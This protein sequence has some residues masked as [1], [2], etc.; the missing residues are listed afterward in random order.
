MISTAT[1]PIDAE[2]AKTKVEIPVNDGSAAEA[3]HRLRRSLSERRD[4]IN[5]MDVRSRP[6]GRPY[7]LRKQAQSLTMR[8]GLFIVLVTSAT[9]S[10]CRATS[11]RALMNA[12]R[13]SPAPSSAHDDG[14]RRAEDAS[15]INRNV[16]DPTGRGKQIVSVM[17][18]PPQTPITFGPTAVP[19][20]RFPDWWSPYR[21]KYAPFPFPVVMKRIKVDRSPG[22]TAF[23]TPLT[24]GRIRLY[25]KRVQALDVIRK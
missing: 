15:Q 22:Y 19:N 24:R 17:Q 12:K 18:Q 8:F 21:A 2:N 13:H 1:G 4:T 7:A 16:L 11:L 6:S 5:G 3:V 23:E 20:P 10:L 14:A 9:V 25:T